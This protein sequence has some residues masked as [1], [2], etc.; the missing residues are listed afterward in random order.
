MKSSAA[1]ALGLWTGAAVVAAVGAFYWH[2]WKPVPATPSPRMEAEWQA[3]DEEIRRLRQEQTRWSA[4]EQRLRQTNTELKSNLTA[5]A[6]TRLDTFPRRIPFHR[7]TT[8]APEPPD[9]PGR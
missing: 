7:T 2:V 5:R 8:G 9:R 3:K 4:E 1:F 6:V